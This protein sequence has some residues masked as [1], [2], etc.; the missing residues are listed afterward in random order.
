MVAPL[1]SNRCACSCDLDAFPFSRGRV[2]RLAQD[3][4]A[5]SV[6]EARLS[7]RYGTLLDDRLEE[8][9]PL[10]HE[11]VLPAEYVS[12]RPPLGQERVLGLGDENVAE[13]A[14]GF[15]LVL[16]EENMQPVRVLHVPPDRA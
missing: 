5:V 3:G 8:V 16:R 4:R 12:R 9:A 13:A 7:F 6:L 1:R 14:E 2:D 15:A 11:A 10:V